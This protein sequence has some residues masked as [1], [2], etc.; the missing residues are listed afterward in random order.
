MT[1]LTKVGRDLTE[2]SRLTLDLQ[3]QAINDANHH[4]IPGGPAM[5]AL[6]DVANLEAWEWMTDA[7]IGYTAPDLEDAEWEPPY[8]TVAYWSERWRRALGAEYDMRTTFDTEIA[9]VRNALQWAAENEEA[10]DN[11]TAD[12][13]KARLRLENILHAGSRA[14]RSRVTCDRDHCER[15]PRLIRVYAPRELVAAECGACGHLDDPAST[16]DCSACEI[17]T[18]A[19]VWASD[20]ADDRWKCPAC[21]HFFGDDE[22]ARARKVQ[23]LNDDSKKW[24]PLTDAR[25][26]LAEFGRSAETIRK[27]VSSDKVQTERNPLTGQ[28]KVWWPDLWTLHLTTKTRRRAA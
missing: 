24:V 1:E 23:L 22:F 20:P 8:Q 26:T 11:F 16:G 17:G 18:L 4:D 10:W 28:V 12:I 27:W 5:V 6:A 21:G 14:K 19:E 3:D 13:R 7:G 9:F 25:A 15:N 2:L